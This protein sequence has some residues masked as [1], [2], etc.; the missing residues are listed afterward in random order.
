[1][2]RG[3]FEMDSSCLKPRSS[4]RSVSGSHDQQQLISSVTAARASPTICGE[5]YDP[6]SHRRMRMHK[7]LHVSNGFLNEATNF[8]WS[9]F[10]YARQTGR[11]NWLAFRNECLP[12]LEIREAPHRL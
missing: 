6:H 1:M 8:I 10:F 3:E 9:G 7:P 12:L 11:P 5:N 4:F 2:G